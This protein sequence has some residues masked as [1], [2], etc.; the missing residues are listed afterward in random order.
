MPGTLTNPILLGSL[1]VPLGISLGPGS[2]RSKDRPLPATEGGH[3]HPPVPRLGALPLARRDVE[4]LRQIL[5]LQRRLRDVTA[6]P[7]AQ[8]ALAHRSLFREALTWFEIH[9]DAPDLVDN[10]KAL[11]A[12]GPVEGEI[13]P[14]EG[15]V[16][17][18]RRRRR[19]RRRRP[20]GPVQS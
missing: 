13:G 3:G 8:R 20:A 5:G 7:R 9:G 15:L 16:P 19:R 11:L 1:L 18:P 12:E 2:G 4:R 17:A 6:S 14:A 10:W